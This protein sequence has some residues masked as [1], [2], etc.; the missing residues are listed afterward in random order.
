MDFKLPQRNAESNKGTYGKVLNIAGSKYMRGAA[1]L[2]SVSALKVGCGYVVLASCEEVLSD[3]VAKLPEVV[4][5]P[6]TQLQKLLEACD[7]V[8]VGCGLSLEKVSFDVVE[9]VLCKKLKIPIVIDADG[10]NILS[11]IKSFDNQENLILTPHPKEAERLLGVEC[12]LILK[13][14]EIYAKEI[15]KKYS[16]VTVLKTHQTVVCSRDLEIY[17]NNTG[18]SGLAKAGSGD[19]LCGMIAGFL[20]QKMDS[21]QACKLAVYLHGLSADIAKNDLTEYGILASDIVRY[22]PMAL[23]TLL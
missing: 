9:Q 15:S 14:P 7:V 16:C 18:N 13:N 3:V 8:S 6:I 12:S 23:K 10:L 2:S 4:L 17:K 5:A 19:I 1:F 22:I 20:A 11:Q 21:F